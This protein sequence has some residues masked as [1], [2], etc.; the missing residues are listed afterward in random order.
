MSDPMLEDESS[1]LINS[2][3]IRFALSQLK[4]YKP[5]TSEQLPVSSFVEMIRWGGALFCQKL[6][7]ITKKDISVQ[8]KI[9]F[10]F[11]HTQRIELHMRIKLQKYPNTIIFQSL[12]K[13]IFAALQLPFIWNNSLRYIE[14]NAKLECIYQ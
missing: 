4:L 7:N 2:N 1:C 13:G 14:K 12:V 5:T 9:D 11:S 10:T 8:S 3:S 6:F